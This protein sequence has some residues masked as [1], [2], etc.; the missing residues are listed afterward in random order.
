[1]GVAAPAGLSYFTRVSA[2]GGTTWTAL[3]PLLI[4]PAPRLVLPQFEDPGHWSLAAGHLLWRTSDAGETWQSQAAAIPDSLSISDLQVVGRGVMWV[5]GAN[6]DAPDRL[7]R[8]TDR[9]STGR[10]R[11]R[12]PSSW[13]P[14]G[15]QEVARF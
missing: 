4:G 9:V 3:R 8:S 10:T 14:E 15:I 11:G 6:G 13:L 1:V 2:D 7:V 5:V 12:R